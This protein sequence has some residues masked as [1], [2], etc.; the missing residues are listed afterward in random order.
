MTENVDFH[1]N[2]TETLYNKLSKLRI[3]QKTMY[4]AMNEL[5]FKQI[6]MSQMLKNA[7]VHILLPNANSFIITG[8]FIF[9]NVASGCSYAFPRY[10][11]CG[12]G[13]N[14]ITAKK[15]LRQTVTNKLYTVRA[16]HIAYHIIMF[17]M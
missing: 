4:C 15:K 3:T 2:S 1:S 7:T 13:S 17:Y 14:I 16:I 9:R 11:N 10:P 6:P 8:C 12:D 5:P